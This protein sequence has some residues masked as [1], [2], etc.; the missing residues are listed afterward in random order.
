M[1]SQELSK[2]LVFQQGTWICSSVLLLWDAGCKVGARFGAVLSNRE[3]KYLF[4]LCLIEFACHSVSFHF[5]P[6]LSVFAN[7]PLWNSV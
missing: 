7:L 6:F 1:Q 2:Y 3:L 4:L 5:V